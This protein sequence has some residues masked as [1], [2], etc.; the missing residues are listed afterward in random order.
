VDRCLVVVERTASGFLACAPEVPGC[1]ATGS[2]SA[3]A[4]HNLRRAI[5]AHLEF[6]G[7][8]THTAPPRVWLD[9]VDLS[10]TVPTRIGG[11]PPV[12]PMPADLATR[13]A[14][15]GF[16]VVQLGE[17][18]SALFTDRDGVET[19]VR[20]AD[21]PWA[22]VSLDDRVVVEETVR[23][24]REVGSPLEDNVDTSEF[25]GYTLRDIVEVL[26]APDGDYVTIELRLLNRDV[27]R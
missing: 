3:I 16:A 23:G 12:G 8:Q 7:P 15:L 19:F 25:E 9:Y 11:T 10:S 4:L 22:P 1:I 5:A 13:L 20:H 26:E 6:M 2:T 27:T 24:L 21:G 14:A 17:G 18:R